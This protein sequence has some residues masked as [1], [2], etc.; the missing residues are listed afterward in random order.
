M[1]AAFAQ[2]LGSARDLPLTV[3]SAGLAATE[4]QPAPRR[5]VQV[6]SELGLDLRGH[7]TAKV[8]E[9]RLAAADRVLVMELAHLERLEERFPAHNRPTFLLGAYV[10]ASEISDPYGSWFL[11]PY[12]RTRDLLRGAVDRLLDDLARSY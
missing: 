4:G 7:R 1:A 8:T 3:D 6:M 2:A 10:A 11:G 12:R 9:A 5:V